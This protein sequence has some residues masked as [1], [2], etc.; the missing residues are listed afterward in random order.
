VKNSPLWKGD[1]DQQLFYYSV[2]AFARRHFPDV[3]MGIYTVDELIDA[4]AI[5]SSNT[6]VSEPA[7]RGVKAL[8]GR[9][10]GKPVSEG[11]TFEPTPDAMQ[12]AAEPVPTM[13]DAEAEA[14][15]RSVSPSAAEPDVGNAPTQ[16]DEST[17]GAEMTDEQ[18][19]QSPGTFDA[20]AEQIARQVNI[21]PEKFEKW[22]AAKVKLCTKGNK[23]EQTTAEHR[24]A[25]LATLRTGKLD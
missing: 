19:A 9:I 25:W 16:E 1:V 20:R 10:T 5:P 24:A 8:M 12:A 17:A 15:L 2:R 22:V 18:A 23:I 14:L 13:G 21:D 6:T 3:M 7:P 11:Q 4:G